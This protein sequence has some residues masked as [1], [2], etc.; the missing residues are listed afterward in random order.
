[1]KSLNKLF[2]VLFI[3]FLAL[4]VINISIASAENL[5]LNYNT[6]NEKRIITTK[7]AE[8]H[9]NKNYINKEHSYIIAEKIEKGIR[10]L[11]NYLGD[12][13]I[14][15]NFEETGKIEYYIEAKHSTST[16]STIPS[17]GRVY[18]LE[19]KQ[20]KSPYI[21][22]TAHI[23]LDG[24]ASISPD[25]WLKEGVPIYLNSKFTV[26]TP[27]VMKNRISLDELSRIYLQNDKYQLI[28]KYFPEPYFRNKIERS[29]FCAFAGSFVQYIE[30]QYGKKK[31]LELYQ[32]KRQ[33]PPTISVLENNEK[34]NKPKSVEQILGSSI[35]E[36]KEQWLKTLKSQN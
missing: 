6:T 32:S 1:M 18:L 19:V 2:I 20:H 25:Y 17:N 7:H 27:E 5:I 8:L 33:K 4:S 36:V 31:L 11:N 13:Y 34:N 23:I 10:D 26:D 15:Y 14:K 3:S 21:H 9:I 12:K 35:D 16:S 29:V 24:D 28:L 22:E 30:N